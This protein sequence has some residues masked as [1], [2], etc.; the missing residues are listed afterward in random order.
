MVNGAWE[1]LSL[2]LNNKAATLA[3]TVA[4]GREKLSLAFING[5]SYWRASQ[6]ENFLMNRFLSR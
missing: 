6:K 1:R 3:L 5:A 2:L 4:R